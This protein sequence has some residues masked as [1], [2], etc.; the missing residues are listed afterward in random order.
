MQQVYLWL[1]DQDGATRLINDH[2]QALTAL[3]TLS[4]NWGTESIDKQPEPSVLQ[5]TIVDR[6]G[7]L[8]GHTL[9]LIGA[10]VIAQLSREP[11]YSDLP[12]EAIG[13]V[14]TTVDLLSNLYQPADPTNPDDDGVTR[15]FSGR[16]GNEMTIT[17]D[18]DGHGYLIETSATSDLAMLKRAHNQGSTSSDPRF[19]GY[20]WTDAN[21]FAEIYNR[22]Y[23][24]GM[25][26]PDSEIFDGTSH[27][28]VSTTETPSLLDLIHQAAQSTQKWL[29]Y[30]HV[31]Y[32]PVTGLGYEVKPYG[33]AVDHDITL[34]PDLTITVDSAESGETPPLPASIIQGRPKLTIQQPYTQVVIKGNTVKADKD[35]KLEFSAATVQIAD[36]DLP[37]T[38]RTT[39]KS[40]TLD[41]DAVITDQ[42]AGKWGRAVRIP[43][44]DATRRT[45]RDILTAMDSTPTSD[46]TVSSDKCDPIQHPRLYRPEP[47][48]PLII[49]GQ[50]LGYIGGVDHEV[51]LTT[52][53][54][55]L[56]YAHNQGRPILTSTLHT[57]PVTHTT[58]P[59]ITLSQLKP[60]DAPLSRA[61][62][63]LGLFAQTTRIQEKET[64]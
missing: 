9:D 12:Q 3:D 38:A 63:R 61:R 17:P 54:G 4:I 25:P 49:T 46:I 42:S 44:T 32:S 45:W 39:Q 37:A 1:E 47:S 11:Y 15:L 16:L 27:A 59:N 7:R 23:L 55:T 56:T 64:A 48:G 50:K 22:A 19:D 40:L 58:T 21:R 6:T 41:S 29:C 26:W 24:A 13:D 35:G 5:L 14:R 51:P 62:L 33:T 31:T 20:Q 57:A 28:P 60:L 36:T 52:I 18:Q 34:H 53:G 2:T 8:A 43:E 30:E 10:R